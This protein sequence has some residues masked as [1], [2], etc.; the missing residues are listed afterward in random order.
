M[1]KILGSIAAVGGRVLF[2]SLL[3]LSAASCV[4]SNSAVS[5]LSPIFSASD[6][7]A[8]SRN[9]A[10]IL[11]ALRRDAGY[12]GAQVDWYQVTLA[13]F[14]Y[15]DESCSQYFDQLFKL[16]RERDATK[17]A[18]SAIGQTTDAILFATGASKL[19]MAIIAQAFGLSTSL[20]DIAAGTYLYQLPPATTKR[21]VETLM[22][23]YRE[24]A[25]KESNKVAGSPAIAYG[26]IRGYLN[27]CL[28]ATIESELVNHIDSATAVPDPNTTGSSVSLKVGSDNA[29][30]VAA[31]KEVGSVKEKLP[32]VALPQTGQIWAKTMAPT[33]LARI[34]KLLCV[35]PADGKWGRQTSTAAEQF[36][37]GRDETRTDIEKYGI[38]EG[39]ARLL[40]K[41]ADEND[42][43]TC[44]ERGVSGPFVAGQLSKDN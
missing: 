1:K 24:G 18:L 38:S 33:K 36:Y 40:E 43:R 44:S 7:Q 10:T 21:F 39:D 26:Y 3:L 29:G 13:G 34:Q 31:L 14:N 4:D 8:A 30:E 20:A 5:G 23:A 27:L 41:L 37:A 17:S 32:N 12:A 2:L 25:S 19:T 6:V 22:T 15:V 9:R 11:D 35:E 16:N 28:P 42:N